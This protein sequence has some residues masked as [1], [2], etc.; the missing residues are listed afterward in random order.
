M[1]NKQHST[2]QGRLFRNDTPNP[3]PYRRHEPLRK[4]LAEM[5]L[6]VFPDFLKIMAALN[7]I[8]DKNLA[9]TEIVDKNTHNSSCVDR[10]NCPNC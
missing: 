1:R 4:V 3:Q 6:G 10:H 8:S 5:D 7:D 9:P 2:R